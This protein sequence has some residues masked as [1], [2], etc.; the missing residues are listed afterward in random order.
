MK[1]IS[2]IAK[3]D[4]PREKLV[5]MLSKYDFNNYLSYPNIKCQR[6]ID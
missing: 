1:K 3:Q 4:R 6:Q 2:E 5:F